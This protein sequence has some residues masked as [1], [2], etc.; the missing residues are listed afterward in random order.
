MRSAIAASGPVEARTAALCALVA[1]TGLER[2][3]FADM[4]RKQVKAR[5]KEISE[6]S[7]A[8]EAVKKTIAEVQAAVMVA[9]MAA[10]TASTAASTS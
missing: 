1:A 4:D 9:V 8:A 5:L 3:V 2:K 10:T 7:W 6:S